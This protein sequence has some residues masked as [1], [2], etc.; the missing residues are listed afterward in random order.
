VPFDALKDLP[1]QH[2]LVLQLLLLL[3]LLLLLRCYMYS[4]LIA[5][6]CGV[7]ILAFC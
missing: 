7:S 4:D 5:H 2:D 3:L 1:L 6:T